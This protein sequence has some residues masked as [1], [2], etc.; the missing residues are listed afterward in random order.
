[1]HRVSHL[2]FAA[3]AAVTLMAADARAEPG[4][5]GQPGHSIG[6]SESRQAPH[7]GAYTSRPG[8]A[9]STEIVCRDDG[10]SIGI[11]G[12]KAPGRGRLIECLPDVDA[13]PLFAR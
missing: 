9:W 5:F 7:G 8:G 11:E 4:G 13:A 10:R 6:G 2:L 1:M 3:L 12:W